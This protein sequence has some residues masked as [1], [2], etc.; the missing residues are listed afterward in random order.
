LPEAA[1]QNN[2]SG[3]V[4]LKFRLDV[5]NQPIDFQIVRSLGYGCDEEAIRL[6]K[7]F[8][9]QY[10]SEQELTVEVPFVR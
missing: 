7:A 5:N 4:R 9:W 6:V 8:T 2:V 1:R 3:S 10:G